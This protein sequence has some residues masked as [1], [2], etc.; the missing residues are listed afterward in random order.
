MRLLPLLR[1]LKGSNVGLLYIDYSLFRDFLVFQLKI[2]LENQLME[3]LKQNQS[4][5]SLE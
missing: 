3:A 2:L 4:R 1:D 5:N